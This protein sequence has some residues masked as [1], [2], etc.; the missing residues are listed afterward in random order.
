LH[1][2]LGHFLRRDAHQPLTAARPYA[3]DRFLAL[4]L[5][6]DWR[7]EPIGVP[8]ADPAIPLDVAMLLQLPQAPL[9][10]LTVHVRPFRYCAGSNRSH[11][12]LKALKR[13]SRID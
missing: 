10:L 13:Q 4:L 3:Y 9:Y 5:T 1:I 11:I 12:P 2:S 6:E 7:G 8:I